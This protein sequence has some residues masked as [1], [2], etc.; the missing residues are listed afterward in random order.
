MNIIYVVLLFFLTDFDINHFDINIVIPS[1]PV[2]GQAFNLTC[3]VDVPNRF[4]E[5]ITGIRWTYDLGASQD[6]TASNSDASVGPL[7]R[8]GDA[9]TSVLTLNPVKTNDARR[10]YCQATINVFAT[11]DRTS[12]DMTVQSEYSR[13][14]T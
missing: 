11:V 1:V 10:Y 14:I 8:N 5:N 12:R 7:T 9:F 13:L 4:V 6:V 3:R 2:A